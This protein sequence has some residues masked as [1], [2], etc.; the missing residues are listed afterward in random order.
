MLRFLIRK[1]V[2]G[3]D[4][5]WEYPGYAPHSGTPAD[6]ENY[7]YFL[8]AIRDALDALEAETGKFYGLTAALPCGPDL[9]NNIETDNVKHSLT[10]F[11]LM[12]YDFHGSWDQ[13]TN[14]NAPLYDPNDAD[15]SVDGCVKNWMEAG[16][17]RD[18]INI[19][20]PFYG[21][22]YLGSGITGKGQPFSGAADQLT[23]SDDEG[24]PQYFNIA[25]KI[26]GFTSVRDEETMTQI[27]YNSAGFL[28][29]DDER[30]ICDKTEYAMNENLNGYI[31]WE[32]SSTP[33]LDAANNRLNNPDVTCAGGAASPKVPTPAPTEPD[34]TGLW[35]PEAGSCVELS[36][37]GK[38]P[39]WLDMQDLSESKED[40]CDLHF[41]G[42]NSCM[43]KEQNN[44]GSAPT[45]KPT[46]IP[47]STKPTQMPLSTFIPENTL[48]YP[49]YGSDGMKAECIQ[50][51]Q[52][53]SW[54]NRDMLKT[55]SFEC[56]TTY[57]P[58]KKEECN[59]GTDR[60]P[61]YP[62]FQTNT[63]MSSSEHPSWMAGDY[64]QKNQW[65]CC[66][67]FF[68]HD[69]DLLLACQNG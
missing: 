48:Y 10:E 30:A 12:T 4:I 43:E 58:Y 7:T 42:T 62:D 20:L 23:W 40:C 28:S 41:P 18:Q 67:T 45:A 44:N 29:Y 66:E 64:L 51:G 57:F 26:N 8:K 33:L 35:Y 65:L 46:K 56:C 61:Y 16:C 6:K 36:P 2:D 27:A 49:D 3:I 17:P 60:Y 25:K 31:I 21:R 1:T 68:S 9:I 5:D 59:L 47:L 53:P 38:I 55:S 22:S 52:M 34:Y 15:L 63:C 37:T 50:G 11:N 54:M 14:V 39:A 19:G 13:E 69:D 24:S 32:I